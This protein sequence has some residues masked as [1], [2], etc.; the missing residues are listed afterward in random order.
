MWYMLYF[1]TDLTIGSI[2]KY[3]NKLATGHSDRAY[4]LK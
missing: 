4:I 1:N 2:K 3:F